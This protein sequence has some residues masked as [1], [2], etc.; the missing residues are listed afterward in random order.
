MIN[1][2]PPHAKK[3]LR[4]EQL[5]RFVSLFIL[6]L[7]F[8]GFILLVLSI[9]T[10]IM[11]RYQIGS[12]YDSDEFTANLRK[13]QRKLELESAEATRI[14]RHF[15]GSFP[16]RHHS[17]IIAALDEMSGEGVS[18]NQFLF[19]PKGKLTLIG[20]AAT[21]TA[22]SDFKSALEADKRFASVELPLSSLV[23]ERDAAFTVTL[24]LK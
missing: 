18:I 9:P 3:R 5:V 14:I 6:T 2:L 22:L 8:A 10:W 1:L 7:A 21:R 20:V 12:V 13:E 16:N 17:D 23:S 19:D 24:M 11:Q 15:G 4:R